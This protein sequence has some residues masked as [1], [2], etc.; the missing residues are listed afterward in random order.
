MANNVTDDLEMIYD[1]IRA[2]TGQDPWDIP[3]EGTSQTV[4][5]PLATS[6]V[7]EPKG[8]PRGT[9]QRDWAFSPTSGNADWTTTSLPENAYTMIFRI[10]SS[11]LE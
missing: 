11:R 8:N 7:S 4:E 1:R 10:R 5:P 2:I 3:P 9:G 6:P